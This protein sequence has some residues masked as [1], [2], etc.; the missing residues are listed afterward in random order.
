MPLLVVILLCNLFLIF[1]SLPI[2]KDK[3]KILKVKKM[4]EVKI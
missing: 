2:Q 3:A 4:L 1:T